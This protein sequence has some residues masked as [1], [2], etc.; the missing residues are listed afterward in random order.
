M[1]RLLKPTAL[2][3]AS[4]IAVAAQASPTNRIVTGSERGTYIQIGHD[5]ARM[6]AQPAGIAL[7]AVPSK[8]STENVRRLRNEAGVRLALVQSDV[9][10]AYL[11]EAQNGNA[12]ALQTIRPLRAVLPLYD[13][14]IYFVARADSPLNALHEIA[15][16]RINVG[17]IGS[18]TAL[19]AT[20]LYRKMFNT[21]IA[22]R[23]LSH[24]SNEDALLKLVEGGLDV[25]A[26]VAGQPTRLFT[27]MKPEAR[28]YIKLLRFDPRAPGSAAATETYS[29]S[30][31]RA[32][33]YPNWLTEDIPALTTKA[34][35][36]TY[37]YHNPGLQDT[38]ARF[39]RSLCANF[40]KLQANGHL[41][42]QEVRL[43]LQPLGK[44]WSY[45]APVERELAA[46]KA[47]RHRAARG[48]NAATT[49]ATPSSCPQARS[50]LGLCRP[51]KGDAPAPARRIELM[52]Q[53]PTRVPVR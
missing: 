52:G 37:D 6:V 7:E 12:E 25:V 21:P 50:V 10:Q 30:A 15:D 45:Y 2:L 18:G 48:D 8:G 43:D 22:E 11:D 28:Q 42:W 16:K 3:L 4:S 39:S 53:E 32:A 5:L 13:E 24:L 20:T 17:P 33:S 36:V 38:L 49:A 41:K 46:C 31:I 51:G 19:T 27:D 9:I 14:E 40:D 34:M 44:N 26:I 47:Q 29:P 1:I 35:L 23:N